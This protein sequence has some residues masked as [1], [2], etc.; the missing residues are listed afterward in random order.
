MEN[1]INLQEHS[2]A[3]CSS[4]CHT[5]T[6]KEQVKP[7]GK[8]KST[9]WEHFIDIVNSVTEKIEIVKC[10]YRSKV[11][12]PNPNNGNSTL[13]KHLQSCSKYPYNVDKK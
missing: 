3:S 13:R 4:T 1:H 12:S 7:G 6:N 11:L 8:R 2:N 5:K 10:K 9:Y